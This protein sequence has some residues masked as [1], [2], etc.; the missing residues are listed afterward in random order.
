ME[1]Y[2]E[3]GHNIFMNKYEVLKEIINESN[4][5]VVFT[6]A[7]I[8]TPSGIPDFRSA[9]GIYNQK[10][11]VNYRPE[12]IISHSFF[13]EHPDMFYEF[14]KEKMCYPNAKPN[15]AHKYF[16]DLE[17]KGKNV[18]VVTQNIYGLHQTAGSSRVYELHG[19]IHRN[20]CERCGRLFGLQYVL[21][22]KDVPLCDKCKGLVK[23]DVV[24]YEEGLDEEV[25]NQAIHAIMQADT[26]IV[27]G[28]SLTVYPAAGFIRYFRGSCLILLNKSST[29]YDNMADLVINEDIVK[30]IEKIN[31]EKN[32]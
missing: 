22:S 30:I 8:S 9:D 28:T 4:S 11:K 5:I 25:I 16:A 7:G 19:S 21:N 12:E 23:P 1:I 32:N 17:K 29:S 24:L 10:A 15:A 13:M 20:Y 6:G 14:Y 3:K 31:E 26:L 18:I 2:E 27:I